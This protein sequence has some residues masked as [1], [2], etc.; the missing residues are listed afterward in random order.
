MMKERRVVVTGCGAISSVGN[1]VAEMWDSVVNGRCGLDRVTRFN[2]EGFRTQ[3]AGELKDF[4]ITKYMSAKEAKRLDLFTQY[5]VAAADEAVQSA[6]LPM[7]LRG[8]SI[9]PNRVGV[10]VSS[11]IGEHRNTPRIL[12]PPEIIT[13]EFE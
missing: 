13:V 2:P 10:I 6:G 8:S 11:G 1:S 3:I 4:D 9:D 7:D 12:C 5:A